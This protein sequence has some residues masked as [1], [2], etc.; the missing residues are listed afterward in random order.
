[1]THR[2]LFD[3]VVIREETDHYALLFHPDTGQSYVINPVSVFI[4]RLLDGTRD[5]SAIVEAIR[6]H[7][8]EVP[9]TMAQEVR[10]FLDLLSRIGLAGTTSVAGKV[11]H[12]IKR[13]RET[14]SVPKKRV[15]E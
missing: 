2:K 1:M 13:K 5:E 14:K 10:E 12:P 3:Q 7:F 11:T 15:A 4:C 6:Q 8:A 9:S